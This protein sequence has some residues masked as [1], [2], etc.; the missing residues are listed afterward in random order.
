GQF[1]ATY[2]KSFFQGELSP[3]ECQFM[4]LGTSETSQ[5]HLIGIMPLEP[6]F[7][8]ARESKWRNNSCHLPSNLR[9]KLVLSFSQSLMGLSSTKTIDFKNSGVGCSSRNT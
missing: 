3:S 1:I 4:A 7:A 6:H 2:F 9:K 8:T 5:D